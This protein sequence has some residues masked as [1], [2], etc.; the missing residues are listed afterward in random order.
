MNRKGYT[1]VELITTLIVM[2]MLVTFAYVTYTKV[3]E[4][5]RNQALV[6]KIKLIETKA[7]EYASNT[8]MLATNVNVLIKNGY[9]KADNENGDI[10]NPVDKL[11]MNCNVISMREEAGIYY[12]SYIN[13]EECDENNLDIVNSDLEI[14][15]YEYDS[16]KIN[17]GN[18]TSQNIENNLKKIDKY[19]WSAKDIVLV[20]KIKEGSGIKHINSITWD[21]DC[22]D[23]TNI[24]KD[25]CLVKEVAS[26]VTKY[27][28]VVEADYVDANITN[29]QK[30]VKLEVGAVVKIDKIAPI[31]NDVNMTDTFWSNT[32][33]DVYINAYD[34]GSLVNQYAFIK[35]DAPIICSS[36]PEEDY[37]KVNDYKKII[38]SVYENGN[39]YACVKDTVGNISGAQS[40]LVDKIDKVAPDCSINITGTLNTATGWYDKLDA[41]VTFTDGSD[42]EISGIEYRIAKVNGKDIFDISN[43]YQ[44]PSSKELNI[45]LEVKD[46]VGNICRKEETI[47]V[48]RCDQVETI[49]ISDW[50]TCGNNITGGFN[51]SKYRS[52]YYV[53]KIS[54]NICP[55]FSTQYAACPW[56]VK[57]TGGSW[58]C[59]TFGL[60]CMKDGNDVCCPGD[61]WDDVRKSYEERMSL[62]D[63]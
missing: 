12:A 34:T 9:L 21:N 48:D 2:S 27:K 42:K 10:I 43:S 20:V 7:S 4:S 36:I 23:E 35:S 22:K 31:I 53:S 15:K 39:Y 13:E 59:Q 41:S 24:Q 28:V 58:K 55:G 33:K 3:D 8:K 61:S 29:T 26:N 5:I 6:N 45:I 62:Q 63:K 44:L 50:S 40:F 47:K 32:K 17:E 54:G 52:V 16:T 30:K 37:I 46:L 38:G 11:S 25:V 14:L 18:L 60:Y 19:S 56:L 49:P 1:L 57:G 51:N